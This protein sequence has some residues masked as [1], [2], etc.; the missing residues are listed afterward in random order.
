MLFIKNSGLSRKGISFV[1]VLIS[2]VIILSMIMVVI[3]SFIM[4]SEV[5]FKSQNEYTCLNIAKSRIERMRKEMKEKGFDSLLSF[6]ETDSPVDSSGSPV[7]DGS[8]SYKRT[9]TVQSVNNRLTQINV[10]V[11]Y[12]YMGRWFANKCVS[13]A[14]YFTRVDSAKD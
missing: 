11:Y 8:N 6:S 10:D 3:S 7:T 9:T 1:E 2:L 14:T 13:L 4:N 5:T 12:K